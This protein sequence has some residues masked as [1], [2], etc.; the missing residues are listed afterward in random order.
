[1]RFVMNC[2][3]FLACAAAVGAAENRPAQTVC[4]VSGEPVDGSSYA[5]VDGFRV[6]TAG[7]AEADEVRKD[8][9]KDFAALAKRREAAN[10]VVWL[11]PSMHQGVTPES[12]FVQQDGK[13][14]YYC[15]NPCLS[16]IKKNFKAAAGE[17]KRLAE[18]AG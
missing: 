18:E 15:C 3:L 13:R 7:P 9:A 16:R 6:L 17:M 10:P 2:I 12:N 1:M 14:I 5:D 8:P 11:C 4:P